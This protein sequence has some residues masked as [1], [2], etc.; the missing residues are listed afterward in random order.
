V[1]TGGFERL[2]LVTG[3]DRRVL[4][5][6]HGEPMRGEGRSPCLFAN[7]PHNAARPPPRTARWSGLPVHAV[8]PMR[9]SPPG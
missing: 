6:E 8:S 3:P 7:G 9:G 2:P 5:G 4:V 1:R